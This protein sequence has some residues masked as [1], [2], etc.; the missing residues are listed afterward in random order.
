MMSRSARICSLARLVGGHMAGGEWGSAVMY[1]DRDDGRGQWFPEFY[2][3]A[4]GWLGL[5]VV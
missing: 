1:S 5:I 2:V 4:G 3:F